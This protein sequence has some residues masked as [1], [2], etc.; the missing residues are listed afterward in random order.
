MREGDK[1]VKFIYAGLADESAIIL[2]RKE[3]SFSKTESTL[4]KNKEHT[5]QIT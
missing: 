3:N 4:L 5:V 2:Q 1:C